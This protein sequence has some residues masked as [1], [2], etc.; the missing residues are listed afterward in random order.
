MASGTNKKIVRETHKKRHLCV[1]YCFSAQE[2]K[3]LFPVLFNL[4]P[5]KSVDRLIGAFCRLC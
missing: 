1:Y 5:I 2:H 4:T 3:E